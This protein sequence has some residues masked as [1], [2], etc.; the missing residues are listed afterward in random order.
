V[1]GYKTQS[2]IQDNS[3]NSDHDNQFQICRSEKV[4]SWVGESRRKSEKVG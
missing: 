3:I 1:T 2:E 4:G